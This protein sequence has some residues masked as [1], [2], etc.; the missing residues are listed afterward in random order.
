ML[1]SSS[2]SSP[3]SPSSSW[4]PNQPTAPPFVRPLVT[5]VELSRPPRLPLGRPLLAPPP[6]T[7]SAQPIRSAEYQQL[8]ATLVSDLAEGASP[9]TLLRRL[10]ASSIQTAS[11]LSD[12]FN[13]VKKNESSRRAVLGFLDEACTMQAPELLSA[14]E[15]DA[16]YRSVCK[17]AAIRQR[18][19]VKDLQTTIRSA[20][21]NVPAD[22][23]DYFNVR[24]PPEEVEL[25][26]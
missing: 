10:F 25:R 12:L 1:S 22:W 3:S 16:A 11:Q 21:A 13:Y 7:M 6:F 19:K 4:L 23:W 9:S 2:L 14:F 8:L 26:G 15:A 17:Q 5:S 20:F 18:E 24:P